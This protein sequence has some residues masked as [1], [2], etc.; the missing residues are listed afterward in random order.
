MREREWG[1]REGESGVGERERVGCEREGGV[2]CEREGGV[3]ER[4]GGVRES[5]WGARKGGVRERG[6]G[7]VRERG[8]GGVRER[9]WGGVR[10]R[11]WGAR[12]RVGCEREGGVGCEREAGVRGR[13]WGARERVRWGWIGVRE[14]GFSLQKEFYWE[15]GVAEVFV[16]QKRHILFDP[17]FSEVTTLK[18]GHGAGGVGC[19]GGGEIGGWRG[20]G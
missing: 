7:G 3:R 5:G 18:G 4:K 14:G 9:G 11:G 6:W 19:D 10:G 13:G 17:I 1:R 2:G 16:L 8:W 20:R 12:K 15:M